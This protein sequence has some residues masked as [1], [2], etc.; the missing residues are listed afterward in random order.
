MMKEVVSAAMYLD[1]SKPQIKSLI[2]TGA[3]SKA[4]AAG[5]D[6]KEMSAMSYPDVRASG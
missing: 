6:I 2:I 5:A 4:F 1:R 3:G